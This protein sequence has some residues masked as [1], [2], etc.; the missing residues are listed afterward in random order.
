MTRPLTEAEEMLRR[1]TERVFRPRKHT[2]IADWIRGQKIR[3]RSEMNSSLAGTYFNPDKT[4]AVSRI[5]HEF[6]EAEG[7]GAARVLVIMKDSQAGVT[8]NLASMIPWIVENRPGGAV[9]WTDTGANVMAAVD[10]KFRPF[11]EACK[12]TSGEERDAQQRVLKKTFPGMTMTFMGAGS[13][14]SFKSRTVTYGFL[15]ECAG[16]NPINGQTTLDLAIARTTTEEDA[17]I[18][19]FSK[20]GACITVEMDDKGEERIASGVHNGDWFHAAYLE[21]TQE[22]YNVPCPH[23]GTMQEF[24][25]EHL[26]YD[27]CRVSNDDGKWIW[28]ERRIVLEA[29]YLCG[30]EDCQ[31]SECGGKIEQHHREAMM[32]AG[33]WIPPPD[34]EREYKS[35]FPHARPG[36]RSAQHTALLSLFSNLS[37]G[38]LALEHKKT[39]NDAAKARAFL[40]ER[41]GSPYTPSKASG[42]H[43]DKSLLRLMVPDLDY[44]RLFLNNKNRRHIR[45]PKALGIPPLI[46]FTCDVQKPV[47]KWVLWA[48][49]PVHDRIDELGEAGRYRGVEAEP[50]ALDWGMTPRDSG[51]YNMARLR[52]QTVLEGWDAESKEWKSLEASVV[53][54]DSRTPAA[55]LMKACANNWPYFC[56]VWGDPS[57]RRQVKARGTAWF[58]KFPLD[59]GTNINVLHMDANHWAEEC[60]NRRILDADPE[61]PSVSSPPYRLPR[62]LVD[63][64]AFM[65]EVLNQREEIVRGADNVFKPVKWVPVIS[66]PDDY[67]DCFK[68]APLLWKVASNPT[69]IP[70]F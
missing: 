47:F 4:P 70:V 11:F 53:M 36:W 43:G 25:W 38:Q 63:D 48:F 2:N 67:F 5:L 37:F 59:D 34:E 9:Y 40:N 69:S 7:E 13:D 31:K 42:I 66:A 29:Y 8:T 28:D 23:C 41:G 50:W 65:K 21:G 12:V 44:K 51:V 24:K 46:G 56:P 49:K 64:P 57:Y 68:W 22:K 61:Y 15:D 33:K 55:V 3:V 39:L 54:M 16:H 20:P 52:E 62:D 10:E 26:K 27:H 18:V 32:L 45:L 17:K 19:A 1:A 30:N 14:S 58:E 35:L 6:M 60:M